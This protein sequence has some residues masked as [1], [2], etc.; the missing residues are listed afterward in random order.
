MPG[1]FQMENT[2]VLGYHC[3]R[4][5]ISVTTRDVCERE[6]SAVKHLAM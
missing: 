3:E 2:S 5:N 4:R 1:A 6:S